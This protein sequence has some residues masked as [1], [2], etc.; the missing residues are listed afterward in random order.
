[1]STEKSQAAC[2]CEGNPITEGVSVAASRN[3][4]QFTA[5]V[6]AIMPR[7]EGDG[8]YWRVILTRDDD[9]KEVERDADQITVIAADGEVLQDADLTAVIEAHACDEWA[10]IRLS[11]RAGLQPVGVDQVTTDPFTRQVRHALM[12]I[13]HVSGVAVV[14]TVSNRER[15]VVVHWGRGADRMAVG[16]EVWRVVASVFP[17]ARLLRVCWE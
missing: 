16:R 1:M 17:D 11:G 8:D 3:G 13:P 9:L 12:A 14:S 5:A 2:D 6:K 7:K 4:K 15:N 10:V